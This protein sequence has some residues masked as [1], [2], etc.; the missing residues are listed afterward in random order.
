VIEDELVRVCDR[1]LLS[2]DAS[3]YYG[4]PYYGYPYYGAYPYGGFI[5][6]GPYFWGPHWHGGW[7]YGPASM[8]GAV[9]AMAAAKAFPD[10]IGS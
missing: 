7:A 1:R 9:A 2:Y 6:I 5:G 3:P 10:H 4:Y 8:V